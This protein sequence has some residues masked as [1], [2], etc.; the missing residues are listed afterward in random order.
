MT[1]PKNRVIGEIVPAGEG[2]SSDR[3]KTPKGQHSAAGRPAIGRTR[4]LFQRRAI[5]QHKNDAVERQRGTL[6][7]AH[8]PSSSFG[9]G[10][11]RIAYT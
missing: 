10:A 11:E 3:D 5:G 8:A 6:C 4:E 9:Y 7:T 2:P 1:E